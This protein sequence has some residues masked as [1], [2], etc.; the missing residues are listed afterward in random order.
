MNMIDKEISKIMTSAYTGFNNSDVIDG[1][2]SAIVDTRRRLKDLSEKDQETYLFNASNKLTYQG[3]GGDAKI[4]LEFDNDFYKSVQDLFDA[5]D[6]YQNFIIKEEFLNNAPAP[7]GSSISKTE[8]VID[9]PIKTK[10]ESYSSS[11]NNVVNNTIGDESISIGLISLMAN[12]EEFF[13]DI[14]WPDNVPEALRLSDVSKV[15]NRFKE[16]AALI[17]SPSFNV[18]HVKTAFF[19]SMNEFEDEVRC[20]IK[21]VKNFIWDDLKKSFG[22]TEEPRPTLQDKEKIFISIFEKNGYTII[23]KNPDSS[24][25]KMIDIIIQKG[26]TKMKFVLDPEGVYCNKIPK[27]FK[28]GPNNELDFAISLKDAQ[29]Y[30]DELDSVGTDDNYA[31]K[32]VIKEY[33]NLAKYGVN[34]FD[35]E[36]LD[37]S[38]QIYGITKTKLYRELERGFTPTTTI[39]FTKVPGDGFTDLI[40]NVDGY[41]RIYNRLSSD[42]T[43]ITKLCVISSQAANASPEIVATAGKETDESDSTPNPEIIVEPVSTDESQMTALAKIIKA[44][45]NRNKSGLVQDSNVG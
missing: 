42:G 29:K 21:A 45:H 26:E 15:A 27:M 22:I 23:S 37:N 1:S 32:V 33:L 6:R 44:K 39:T 7:V 13:K 17:S 28:V 36:V 9:V 14:T 16:T 3:R 30:F 10:T 2:K 34:L 35:Q 24:T 31:S 20:Y 43:S 5:K 4:A 25:E 41:P 40:L 8:N 18:A 11:D 19:N 38:K 12:L